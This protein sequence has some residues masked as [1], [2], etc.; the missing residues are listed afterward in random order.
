MRN[1]IMVVMFTG[2]LM[3][4]SRCDPRQVRGGHHHGGGNAGS[5]PGQACGP[6]DC[7]S[8]QVCCN[9][10][11]GICTPPGGVCTQQACE[12]VRCGPTTCGVGQECCNESC[13]ICVDPGGACTEQF[14]EAGPFCGGIAAI[15]CPGAGSCVD[16]WRDD[17]DPAH[18]GAD[19]GGVCTCS[20][21]AVL[22]LAGT[23]FNDDPN[24]CACE[25]Q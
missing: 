1:L 6:V 11:C 10:S 5:A 19:C 15:R 4:A 3:G 9:E 24:V 13:G 12:G 14:C 16:D 2:V 18:G 7:P 8:G 17:C 21:A 22:C 20:A 23:V 25:P